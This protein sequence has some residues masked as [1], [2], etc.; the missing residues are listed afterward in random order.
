MHPNL[1]PGLIELSSVLSAL[2]PKQDS[3]LPY[4]YHATKTFSALI[5]K[6]IPSS[7]DYFRPRDLQMVSAL[8]ATMDCLVDVTTLGSHDALKEIV[9]KGDTAASSC[10]KKNPKIFGKPY[11]SDKEEALTAA[12]HLEKLLIAL[13][14]EVEQNG[15][16]L[17]GSEYRRSALQSDVMVDVMEKILQ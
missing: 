15:G 6:V 12:G 7:S 14:T 4:S 13:D 10:R 11:N 17:P 2:N 9:F 1:W 5:E 16:T 8:Q 3:S